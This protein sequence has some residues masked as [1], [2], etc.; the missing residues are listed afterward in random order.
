MLKVP[1]MSCLL[2]RIHWLPRLTRLSRLSWSHKHNRLRRLPRLGVLVHHHWSTSTRA[3]EPA[4]GLRR[5]P[6]LRVD[7]ARVWRI[8]LHLRGVRRN[9][10]IRP[11]GRLLYHHRRCHSLW[12]HKL[13]CSWVVS[14]V[15][16]LWSTLVHIKLRHR[17]LERQLSVMGHRRRVGH[18]VLLES[19]GRENLR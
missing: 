5:W 11:T 2:G 18:M 9:T 1:T 7:V 14:H 3:R 17:L 19:W 12:V 10:H 16:W 8:H 6:M 15:R 4:M 13:R